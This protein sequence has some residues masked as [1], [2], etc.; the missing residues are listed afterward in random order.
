[1]VVDARFAK[2]R[3]NKLKVLMIINIRN[4][5]SIVSIDHFYE[6]SFDKKTFITYIVD[7]VVYPDKFDDNIDNVCS[8][9]IHYFKSIDRAYNY[10]S[11]P[12]SYTGIWYSYSE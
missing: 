8:N 1:L 11:P 12:P 10:A 3:A 2:Y 9:G 4:L 5:S 7:K 6:N